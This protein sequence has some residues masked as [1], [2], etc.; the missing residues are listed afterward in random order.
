MHEVPMQ[1]CMNCLHGRSLAASRMRC[2]PPAARETIACV[3]PSA[4]DMCCSKHG[5][6][7]M[8]SGQARAPSL[9]QRNIVKVNCPAGVARTPYKQNCQRTIAGVAPAIFSYLFN[10]RMCPK[11]RFAQGVRPKTAGQSLPAHLSFEPS[12]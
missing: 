1:S 7:S 11:W 6:P 5:H 10:P 8:G 9:T 4:H 12:V 3:A 2:C